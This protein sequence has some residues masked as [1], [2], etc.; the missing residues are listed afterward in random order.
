MDR[1]ILILIVIGAVSFL[2]TFLAHRYGN[3]TYLKYIFPSL[4]LVLSIF[5]L[6][7]I[8]FSTNEGFKDIAYF[9]MLMMSITAFL[10]SVIAAIIL[11]KFNK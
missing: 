1:F 11:E 4:T 8:N 3:K 2:I 7:K 5:I 9:L 10:V 6:I